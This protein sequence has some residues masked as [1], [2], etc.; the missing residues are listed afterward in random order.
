MSFIH[1]LFVRRERVVEET[2]TFPLFFP[3]C[4]FKQTVRKKNSRRKIQKKKHHDIKLSNNNIPLMQEFQKKLGF[5]LNI[6]AQSL[7]TECLP[8]NC[9]WPGTLTIRTLLLTF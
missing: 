6:T 3:S 1:P 5:T 7:V 9:L 2:F 4:C 8:E